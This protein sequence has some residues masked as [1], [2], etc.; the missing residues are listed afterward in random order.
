MKKPLKINGV[1]LLK[2]GVKDLDGTY[3]PVTYDIGTRYERSLDRNNTF[4]GAVIRAKTYD[5]LPADLF[6]INDS[7]SMTDYFEKDRAIFREG[8]PE[9]E[10]IKFLALK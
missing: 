7:D 5:R 6:P 8:T 4:M 2:K 1:R 3:T 9:F 10:L